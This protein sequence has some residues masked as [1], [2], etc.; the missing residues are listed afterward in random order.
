MSLTKTVQ[1]QGIEP[2]LLSAEELAKVLGVSLRHV[3]R[4][5]AAG[6]LPPSVR[7]GRSVRWRLPEVRRWLDLGAP[8]RAAWRSSSCNLWQ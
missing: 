8:D 7:L 4:L 2:L 1:A 6:R 3:R 5:N